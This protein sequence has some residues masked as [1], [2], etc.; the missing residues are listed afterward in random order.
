ML[1]MGG[2]V[3]VVP[4]EQDRNCYGGLLVPYTVSPSYWSSSAVNIVTVQAGTV[5]GVSPGNATVTAQWMVHNYSPY[6]GYCVDPQVLLSRSAPAQVKRVPHHLK[7][8][9]DIIGPNIVCESTLRRYISYRAVDI[10]G[11]SVTDN[12][13][14][15]ESFDSETPNTCNTPMGGTYTCTAS[16]GGGFT[17]AI[18]VGCNSVGG[19]CGLTRTNQKWYWCRVDPPGPVVIATIGDLIVH[20]DY[21]SVGGNTTGFAAGTEKLP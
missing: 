2:T 6:H 7:V 5:N 9:S 3:L 10:G 17:D 21:I 11:V 4:S 18:S 14:I 15:K 12:V 8:V 19:S 13:L 16:Q 1:L 20:N